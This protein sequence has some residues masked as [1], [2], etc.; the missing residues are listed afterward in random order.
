MADGGTLFLDEIGELPLALQVKLLRFLQDQV[1][2]RVGGGAPIQV[3]VRVIAAT[4]KN[5]KEEIKNGNFREDLYHRLSVILINAGMLP[6]R[7]RRVCILTAPFRLR[8]LAQGK[9]EVTV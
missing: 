4:N 7:S 6:R 8:N 9:R 2:E 1:I 3:D 5:L